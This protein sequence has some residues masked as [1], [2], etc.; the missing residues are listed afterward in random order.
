[1]IDIGNCLL[2]VGTFQ[3]IGYSL[4]GMTTVMLFWIFFSRLQMIIITDMLWLK[5]ST[6]KYWLAIMAVFCVFPLA[7]FILCCFTVSGEDGDINKLI[8]VRQFLSC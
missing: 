3:A 5:L 4:Y 8:L 6:I 2:L 1:M 7:I